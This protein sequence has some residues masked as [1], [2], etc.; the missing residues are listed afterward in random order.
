MVLGR[1]HG[2]DSS[3]VLPFG[4]IQQQRVDRCF[5]IENRVGVAALNSKFAQLLVTRAGARAHVSNI[6]KQADF[7]CCEFNSVKQWSCSSPDMNP[8]TNQ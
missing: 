5:V 3:I 8:Y 7:T 2:S 4:S 1:H 6:E